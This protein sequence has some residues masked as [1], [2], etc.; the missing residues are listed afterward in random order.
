MAKQIKLISD[1]NVNIPIYYNNIS[2]SFYL[3]NSSE[4]NESNLDISANVN[5]NP[6]NFSVE[7]NESEPNL[8][9]SDM[10]NFMSCDVNSEMNSNINENVNNN[11]NNNENFTVFTNNSE[12]E[13]CASEIFNSVSDDMSNEANSNSSANVNNISENLIVDT[14]ES[15][16]GLNTSGMCNFINSNMTN[17]TNS[18]MNSNNVIT[19]NINSVIPVNTG[20]CF[21]GYAANYVY[22]NSVI[23]FVPTVNNSNLAMS[24]V[25]PAISVQPTIYYTNVPAMY[26]PN[27]PVMYYPNVVH[28][29]PSFAIS[30]PYMVDYA[31]ITQPLVYAT[32]ITQPTVSHQSSNEFTLY[33]TNT[34]QP[35]SSY[36]NG[37]TNT[38][39][40]PIYDQHVV[41]STL[42]VIPTPSCS[43]SVNHSIYEHSV[44]HSTLN[45][46]NTISSNDAELSTENSA[47]LIIPTDDYDE[48][49]M[50]QLE[51]TGSVVDEL[52]SSFRSP[53]LDINSTDTK[54]DKVI[55]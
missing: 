42:N 26:Y 30:T 23:D 28:Q 7:G 5:T 33:S 27:V 37:I 18:N 24:T 32:N 54:H 29:T 36:T 40:L 35:A 9:T 15:D 4:G 48:L 31:N 39:S 41:H 11:N 45:A 22:Q 25:N 8:N 43:N 50:P 47:A 53:H 14:G 3:T 6:E 51:M 2:G 19:P 17:G 55:D 52:P 49:T 16:P 10:M 34:D 12:P 21:G 44:S 20:Y 13:S 46:M 1:D 38:V